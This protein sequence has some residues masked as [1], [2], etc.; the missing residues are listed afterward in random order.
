MCAIHHQKKLNAAT[1]LQAAAE[2]VNA[3]K[4]P[5]RFPHMTSVKF[6]RALKSPVSSLS[7]QLTITN[8][9][10]CP[11]FLFWYLICITVGWP[12]VRE[13]GALLLSSACLQ[14]ST[15]HTRPKMRKIVHE[16]TLKYCHYKDKNDKNSWKI[17]IL[18]VFE[19]SHNFILYER[20][21]VVLALCAPSSWPPQVGRSLERKENRPQVTTPKLSSETL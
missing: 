8:I 14:S 17:L 10:F 19:P 18:T 13:I 9:G 5:S 21:F 1:V 2:W 11:K 3:I 12:L 6:F 20:F 7:L 4:L 16:K 15:P